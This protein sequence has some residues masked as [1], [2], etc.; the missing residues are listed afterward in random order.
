[1][2]TLKIMLHP[3][4]KD[5]NGKR[6]IVLRL[7][8]NRVK[9]YIDLK[10][11]ERF[12]PDHFSDGKIKSTS[13]IKL[14]KQ[15]N[16]FIAQ[17][18]GDAHNVL[19]DLEKKNIP[20]TLETF[21]KY[22]FKIKDQNYVFPFF[23]N[24]VKSLEQKNKIGNSGIYK[25]VRNSLWKYKPVMRLRFTDI[26]L[27]FLEDYESYLIREKLK[28]NGIALYMRT[29]RSAYNK[30]IAAD[31]TSSDLYPF[32]NQLNPKGF[33]ISDLET[34]TKKRAISLNT[35][36][37][38]ENK[39]TKPLSSIHDA[40]LYF[41]FSFY[42]RG[43]NF[44]DMAELTKDNIIQNRIIYTRAKTRHK[45][46]FT[47]EILEPVQKI[48]DYFSK[49][50]EIG[51]YLLPI[52]NDEIYKTPKQ[53]KTRIQTVLKQVNRR[54]KDLAGELKIEPLT[55]YVARHS[56][57]TIQKQLGA[58]ISAISEGMGHSDESTTTIYLKNFEDNY[59]DELNRKL[60]K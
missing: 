48:L 44:S 58:P 11:N 8:L 6:K 47:I 26:D 4:N 22:F 3:I 54:L 19:L 23:D 50:P 7:T 33:K 24:L 32:N 38:I 56:W 1:M 53:K 25:T 18:E 10:I 59:L 52:L 12:F 20:I 39:Q 15:I 40:K 51:N 43:M 37:S 46:K 16:A 28:G 13:G 49:H 14:Y 57:A 29:L 21:K 9:Y 30:A 42:T 36:R 2:A 31:I 41:L 17:R 27:K 35:I 5:A 34:A 55:T 45:Q 60:L